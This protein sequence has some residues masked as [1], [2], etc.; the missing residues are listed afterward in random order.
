MSNVLTSVEAA[1]LDVFDTA[2][3][4]HAANAAAQQADAATSEENLEPVEFTGVDSAEFATVNDEEVLED[5]ADVQLFRSV[6]Q[7][8]RLLILTCMDYRI[9]VPAAFGLPPGR[10]Y[11]VRNAGGRAT[12]AARSIIISQAVLGT[13]DIWVVHHTRCGMSNGQALTQRMYTLLDKTFP[14]H[15]YLTRTLNFLPLPQDLAQGVRYDVRFLRFH[16][17][18]RSNSVRGF[19]YNVDNNRLRE[20]LV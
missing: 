10:A 3:L 8:R 14:S 18:V 20:I 16:P 12:E 11:V 13:T 6:G 9:D 1:L 2:A 19:E 7:Q 15:Q 5:T 17:L 4:S